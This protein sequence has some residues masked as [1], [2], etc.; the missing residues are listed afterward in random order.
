MRLILLRM[1]RL[2]FLQ[3]VETS[4][5]LILRLQLSFIDYIFGM[6]LIFYF[7]MYAF[8]SIIFVF[9]LCGYRVLIMLLNEVEQ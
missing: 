6:F 5:S 3:F 2:F 7:I 8:N 1:I 4:E 9:Y